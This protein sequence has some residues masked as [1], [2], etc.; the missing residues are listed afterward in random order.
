MD[1]AQ[2][3]FTYSVADGDTDKIELVKN[4]QGAVTGVKALKAGTAKINVKAEYQ[5]LTGADGAY[6]TVTNDAGAKAE[7][8]IQI[9][10]NVTKKGAAS[11]TEKNELNGA[12]SDAETTYPDEVEGDYQADAW[13]ELQNAI[14]DAKALAA[15]PNATSTQVANAKNR[16]EAAIT[17]LA[18]AKSPKGIAKD[19][20]KAVLDNAELKALIEGNNSDKKYTADSFAKLTAAYADA[21][22][23]LMTADAAA[24][25][26]LKTTLEAAWKG[27][28]LASGG[29]NGGTGDSVIANG[30]VLTGAD[31]TKYQVVSGKD[32]TVTITKGVDAKTVKVGPTVTIGKDTFKVVG[33]GNKAYTGLKKATKVIINANV[34]TIGDQAFE[35]S[36][37]I[38][39]V[40]IGANVTKIGK[41]AFF[42]CPK[43]NKV[44]FKGTALT[45]K[46]VGGKAFAKTAKKSSVKWGKIKG[47]ARTK[48]SKK[49]KKAG[50]KIK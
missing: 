17:A 25:G 3:K 45:D 8:T 44:T 36:K 32:K 20:L 11:S 16:I 9:T 13:Q 19:A 40:T 1:D 33:I 47:K 24:L 15:D 23:K 50:L 5:L 6:E 30:T 18:D 4:A 37:K 27:L 2:I 35:K 49:L 12:A 14:A 41:K 10:V 34:E 48:L 42:N 26:T 22:S 43:L 39:N 21:N 38:K 7:K 31:G 46:G 28:V 29:S